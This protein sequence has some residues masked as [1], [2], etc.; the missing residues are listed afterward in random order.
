M[1]SNVLFGMDIILCFFTAFEDENKILV[2][3]NWIIA[4][5]YLRTWF[6]IDVLSIIPFSE[7]FSSNDDQSETTDDSTNANA[8]SNKKSNYNS[9]VRLARLP[10]LYKL[11]RLFK[12][13]RLSKI[14][15][16]YHNHY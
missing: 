15:K 2:T 3:N 6:I 8:S 11:I 9:L 4:K 5:T 13:V 12:L 1:A 7:I 14:K 16:I 10:R